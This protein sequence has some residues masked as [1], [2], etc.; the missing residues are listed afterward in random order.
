VS[1]RGRV[2]L[3]SSRRRDAKRF[4]RKEVVRPCEA[5][6]VL[7]VDFL[8]YY[9]RWEVA[10]I[11]SGMPLQ[12]MDW[13]FG[14]METETEADTKGLALGAECGCDLRYFSI[15]SVVSYWRAV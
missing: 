13:A 5:T 7:V 4:G 6:V 1:W 2:G 12:V 11:G 15:A 10:R 3:W 9:R 14:K 8:A